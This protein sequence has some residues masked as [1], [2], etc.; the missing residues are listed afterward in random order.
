MY[1]NYIIALQ[2]SSLI[3]IYDLK[4]FQ[5]ISKKFFNESFKVTLIEYP[6]SVSYHTMRKKRYG[7]IF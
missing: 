2:F 5:Q 1:Y 3:E 6:I 4:Q 7:M